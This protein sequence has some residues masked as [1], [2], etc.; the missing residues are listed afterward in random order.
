MFLTITQ[1]LWSLIV[2]ICLTAFAIAMLWIAESE[3]GE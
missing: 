2:G 1:A 3:T